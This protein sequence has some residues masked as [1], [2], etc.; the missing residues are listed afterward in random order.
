MASNEACEPWRVGYWAFPGRSPTP[1]LR[2]QNMLGG[3][4]IL[5]GGCGTITAR[6][7]LN[8]LLKI[9][10]AFCL[11]RMVHLA[12]FLYCIVI[13][14]SNMNIQRMQR[15]QY[16]W[17]LGHANWGFFPIFTGILWEKRCHLSLSIF[18]RGKN[19]CMN[20]AL[21]ICGWKDK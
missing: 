1:S 6:E 17:I 14:R 11:I 10:A 9:V 5:L 8:V 12:F 21:E 19:D 18:P 16:D 20:K 2:N 7:Y 15:E 4:E 3:L 13:Y